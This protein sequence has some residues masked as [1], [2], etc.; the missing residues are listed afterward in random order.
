V[1]NE[2]GW[3]AAQL[4]GGYRA[5]RRQN[6]LSGWSNFPGRYR[7][8]VVC[9]L[10]GSGKSRL[11][12][13]LAEEGAQALDLEAMARHRGSLLGDLPDRPQPT[14]K[15]FDS[16]LIEALERLDPSRP[17]YIESESRKIG[18]V[19]LRTRCWTRCVPPSASALCC[20]GRCGSR[21]EGRVRPLLRRLRGAVRAA[22]AARSDPWQAGD[23]PMDGRRAG[24]ATGIR[25]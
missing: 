16:Q 19:Q 6:R 13:A 11:I 3:R 5:Y 23:R 20:R 2:I 22:R 21:S 4:D 7:Y 14:Q 10:T 15:S 8:L 24:P 18:T 12:G 9:G 1:L 25:S 17:V